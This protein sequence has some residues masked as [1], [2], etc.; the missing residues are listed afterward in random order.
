[1]EGLIIVIGLMIIVAAAAALLMRLLKQPLLLGY[2]AAGILLGPAA[3][4]LITDAEPIA[5]LSELGLILLMFVIG[6]ELDLSRVKEVGMVSVVIGTLQVVIVTFLTAFLTLLFG[7]SFL[8]GVYIGLLIA[9]S[10]TLIVVKMLADKK[11]L[12]S[13]HGELTLGVLVIQDV[14]AVLG[15][16][17]LGT[18]KE[19]GAAAVSAF[20]TLV[21][22]LAK[23]GVALPAEG[24]F[25]F[26]ILLGNA[27]LF[28]LIVYV[29]FKHL[30]PLISRD[31]ASSSELLFLTA[32][33]SAFIVSA[34]AGF[35]QFSFAI[36][37]FAAGIAL[38]STENSHEIVGRVK[39]LKDFFLILFFVTLGVQITPASLLDEFWLI[40][41]LF[42]GGLIIKP[43][44]T[45]FIMKFF[46]YN[47]RT[48]FMTSL[49]LAQIGEFGMVLI[50]SGV[51]VGALTGGILTAAVLTTIITMTLATYAIKYSDPLYERVKQYLAPL[52]DYFGTRPEETR[53]VPKRYQP[54][55]VI[56]G[57]TP[58]TKHIIGKLVQQQQKIL[59]VDHNPVKTAV[60]RKRGIPTMCS[61][62][63]NMDLYE[64]V[65]FSKAEVIVSMLPVTDDRIMGP[66]G[67]IFL[68]KNVRKVNH[69]AVIIMSAP[70]EQWGRRLSLMGATIVLTPNILSRRVL[71][72]LLTKRTKEE[73]KAS[74]Q[75]Y[76]LEL[77][78][79]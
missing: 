24:G 41:F 49:H 69:E 70:T 22:V 71:S 37:A 45:F 54:Q 21:D 44:V 30:L 9:F 19:E 23:F 15:L 57:V 51:A 72:S 76:K 11:E 1:M 20:P 31:T 7:F 16:T 73:L 59:I 77:F 14:L 63:F 43:V 18:F 58:V 2:V 39:P 42:F 48:S 47:N 46:R 55:T 3:F 34:L 75:K 5:L 78:H 13:L 4:G 8:Q 32:L 68:L 36:G 38:S 25:S 10:S 27:V 26:L 35:F 50:A 56:F 28:S 40:I 17:L 61:D 67:N 12:D 52:D 6:L 53:N 62:A 66:N 64:T 29:V 79:G 74:A 33:A 60:Y 65:D